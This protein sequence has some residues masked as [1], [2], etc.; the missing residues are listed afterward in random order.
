MN[1]SKWGLGYKGL[2]IV[3]PEE[4]NIVVDAL[5]ELDGRTAK[6]QKGG[7]TSFSGDGVTKDFSFAHGLSAV[8]TV[9]LIGAGSVDAV[10][11]LWWEATATEIKVHYSVAPP[12]GTGNISLFWL[13]IRL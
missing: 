12:L 4:W 8:P 1:L 6:E 2:E 9:V 7:L 10:G 11:D 5:D 3:S 13:A